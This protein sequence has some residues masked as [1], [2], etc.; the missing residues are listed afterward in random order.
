MSKIPLILAGLL[1]AAAAAAHTALQSSA[2]ADGAALAESPQQ[3]ALTFSEPV[4]L[5]AVV[6]RAADGIEH[7]I[8]PLPGDRAE[9]FALPAPELVPGRYTV[10]WR[11]LSA[12]THVVS[13]AIE[14]TVEAGALD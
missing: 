9:Q 13:G 2:P 4:R 11:A 10:D 1:V 12:D 7:A 5:T 6:V 14:F 8:E 3:I